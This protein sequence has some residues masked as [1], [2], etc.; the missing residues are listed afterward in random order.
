[1]EPLHIKDTLGP[2]ML[3]VFYIKVIPSLWRFK[4]YCQYMKVFIWDHLGSFGTIKPVIYMENFSIVSFIQSIV[5]SL[6]LLCFC[7]S[8][9]GH[10]GRWV[11]LYR[12]SL[13]GFTSK[14]FHSRCD[15]NGPT[16]ILIKVLLSGQHDYM[17][18]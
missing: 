1:M 5:V 8:R 7:M 10:R 18:L 13:H 12:A 17:S 9:C 16:L 14:D 4:I 3:S 15:N 11:L 6:Y 2:G